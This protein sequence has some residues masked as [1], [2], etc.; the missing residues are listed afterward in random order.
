MQVTVLKHPRRCDVSNPEQCRQFAY[1]GIG[2]YEDHP[3]GLFAMCEKHVMAVRAVYEE[4][5]EADDEAR[6]S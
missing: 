4:Q 6:T 2:G 1:V 5:K 3:D